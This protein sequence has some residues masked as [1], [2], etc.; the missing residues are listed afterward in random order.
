VT[1]IH[2]LS[3]NGTHTGSQEAELAR[4][5]DEYL[6]GLEAGRPADV[7]GL[8]ER[9]PAIADRLRACLK[10]LQLVEEVAGTFGSTTAEG[11]PRDEGAEFGDFRI[12]RPL[13][14]G[15]MGVVFEAV[16]HS[17]GRHVA[18]KVLPFGAAFDPRQLARFRVESQAAAQLHH[19]HIVPVYSVGCERGVH[20][21][22]MQLIDGPTL[23]EV[24]ADLRRARSLE[25]PP[26]PTSGNRGASISVSAHE[27]NCAGDACDQAQGARSG[28]PAK[29]WS[30]LSSTSTRSGAFVR[31]IGGLAMNAALALEHAHQNGV[32]HRDV[33]PSNL[34]V[35]SRNHLWVTD[36]GLARFQGQGSLTETGDVLG[37]LRYMSPEQAQGNSSVVDQRTDIYS[38]GATLY[39]LLTLEPAFGGSDRQ[40]LLGRIALEEPPRPRGLNPAIPAD[41]ETII[42]KAMAK[43]P[44]SRYASA[45]A[46][47]ED[48][49]RFLEDQPILARRPSPVERM[50]RLA[51]RHVRIIMSV[52]PLLFVMV[53][54]LTLGIVLV[55]RE[56]AEILSKQGEIESKKDEVE[57]SRAEVKRQRDDARR[58]VDEMYTQV[59]EEWLS[60]QTNLQPL[61]RD[62]LQKALAYYEKFAREE[63]ADPALRIQRGLASLRVG[64]IQRSL[65]KFDLAEQAFRQTLAI[66]D[67]DGN[68]SDHNSE[69][70]DALARA[71]VGLADVLSSANRIEES[72]K[73]IPRAVELTRLFIEKTPQ[74][75]SSLPTLA[76]QHEQL[77]GLLRYLGRLKE[78]EQAYRTALDLG[79]VIGNPNRLTEAAASTRLGAML[80]QT[81]R[82]AEA[83]QVYRH[84]VELHESLVKADPAMP[85]YRQSLARTLTAMAG[86]L[87]KQRGREPDVEQTYR[88]ASALYNRLAADAP[89]MPAIRYELGVTLIELGKLL[90]KL[91]RISEAEE[92]LRGVPAVF[93]ALIA[94][95][96][97]LSN[98]REKLAASLTVLADVQRIAGQTAIAISNARKAQEIYEKLNAEN[99]DIRRN[100]AKN[101]GCL[102][103]LL[104]V[105]A[106][107]A[108]AEGLARRAVAILEKVASER[109]NDPDVR[110]ELAIDV[111]Q[112]AYQCFRTGKPE[113]A[114]R[115]YRR[116]LEML[117]KLV[118]EAPERSD[119][120][121]SLARVAMNLGGF[122]FQRNRF[123]QAAKITRRA[124]E[125]Y[126]HLI[127][128]NYR[129]DEM[130]RGAATC[131]GNLAVTQIA[132]ERRADGV[133][134]YRRALELLDSLPGAVKQQIETRATRANIAHNLAIVLKNDG[135]PIE[136][137]NYLRQAEEAQ[138]ALATQVPE[139]AEYRD[140]LSLSRS[141][142][143]SFLIDRGQLA[144]AHRLLTEAVK[145][146][147]EALR[148][149]PGNPVGRAHLRGERKILAAFLLKQRAH[150]EAAVVAEDMLRDSGPDSPEVPK[151]AATY[152][153][154]CSAQA[155]EDEQLP[156][157]RRMAAV[158]SY[159]I[160][161]RDTLRQIVDA[162]QDA[163]AAPSL[164]WLL[165]VCPAAD[166]R[167][168][169]AALKLA[170]ATLKTFPQDPKSTLLLGAALY[171]S[172][173]WPGAIKAISKG[174]DMNKGEIGYWGFFLAMAHWQLDQ[175]ELARQSFERSVRWIAANPAEVDAVI[176]RNEAATL[177]GIPERGVPISTR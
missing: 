132:M 106:S 87:S 127:T 146:E 44:A 124:I 83:Q 57:R 72:D 26:V 97:N 116:S 46:L 119:D 117:E 165:L 171:R 110:S 77:G 9:H 79:K 17:L 158:R 140:A 33:K 103:E 40:E 39:E 15:G 27:N 157:D 37:T 3:V 149:N 144:E 2:E 74:T 141:H 19:T 30:G 28:E 101:L 70:L 95:S 162:G 126:E 154:I 16:Q 115:A 60:R 41:L 109:P 143:G 135:H 42:L 96:R 148:V 48:L 129:R 43:D 98:F 113:E 107:Y 142:L 151:T 173:D 76:Y 13:G 5:L 160:R 161:A 69:T 118:A 139:N 155:W 45:G 6:A 88:R 85:L 82:L 63:D 102:V 168:P 68:T 51:R 94:E 65:G 62:F 145:L 138:A 29:G 174:S 90:L 14:R 38:L 108:E 1:P 159:A 131:L 122:C 58:A 80:E 4:V 156:K 172:G 54:G 67:A 55:L 7:E 10:G 105:S 20:Y 177:L 64:A 75:P 53:I 121:L 50:A 25:S 89:E 167:D 56:Q 91:R 78:S 49:R 22:A 153:T 18:L 52:L 99:P 136:A 81:G 130:L 169:P 125:T 84:A 32:L 8:I 164:C 163:T 133:H 123:D 23:A 47:A 134:S 86:L 137:E 150:A 166:F 128:N 12:L 24:I 147:Q 93:E 175:K 120:W 73:L 66:L 11:S 61:Q 21:Y 104:D 112:L 59:A 36:F 114:D 152:W 31:E 92:V 100:S 111:H 176:L 34:M 71:Y 35:D 170:R